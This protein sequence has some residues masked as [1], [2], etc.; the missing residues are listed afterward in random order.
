M[1]G[2]IGTPEKWNGNSLKR[3]EN[4]SYRWQ[5]KRIQPIH[6]WILEAENQINRTEQNNSG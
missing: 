5:A 3:L 6:N 1:G 4:C 2:K